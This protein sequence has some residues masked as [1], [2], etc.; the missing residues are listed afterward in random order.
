[1]SPDL[2]KNKCCLT[3]STCV[4]SHNGG[5]NNR[6]RSTRKYHDNVNTSFRGHQFQPS[7]IATK[8]VSSSK[9]IKFVTFP[10]MASSWDP[11]ALIK[12]HYWTHYVRQLCILMWVVLLQ[13][14]TPLVNRGEE[15]GEGIKSKECETKK[16]SKKNVP[17]SL[18]SAQH[19]KKNVQN[20][21][22]RPAT[23]VTCLRNARRILCWLLSKD[24]SACWNAF[25]RCSTVT[26]LRYFQ[27]DRVVGFRLRLGSSI[28]SSNS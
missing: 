6:L 11:G 27:S 22:P 21:D 28:C 9:S 17:D 25:P 7:G 12:L 3:R 14:S 8:A 1:M 19:G 5:T 15:V 13:I 24:S 18:K 23:A 26:C 16:V 4:M 2:T 20:T 10:Y